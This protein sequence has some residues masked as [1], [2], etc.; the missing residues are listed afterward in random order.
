MSI[1]KDVGSCEIYDDVE[2]D[3]RENGN[4]EE[5]CVV[6]REGEA[7]GAKLRRDV[8][9][10]NIYIFLSTFRRG[11]RT[12]HPL[13][14]SKSK[15]L[16]NKSRQRPG[17]EVRGQESLAIALVVNNKIIKMS[18]RAIDQYGRDPS[19]ILVIAEAGERP[20]ASRIPVPK[21]PTELQ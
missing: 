14:S 4:G 2:F 3:I 19:L 20:T 21:A 7:L 12:A 18:D 15:K 13:R 8:F 1:I 5:R 17:V 16:R 11:D 9:I 6:N 10:N